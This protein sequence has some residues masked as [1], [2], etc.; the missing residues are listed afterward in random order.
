[1]DGSLGGIPSKYYGT[2][3]ATGVLP[4][5]S[6]AAAAAAA[7]ATAPPGGVVA[8]VPPGVAPPVGH[9]QTPFHP[10][11]SSAYASFFQHQMAVMSNHN[12]HPLNP[13]PHQQ[14]SGLAAPPGHHAIT[15]AIFGIPTTQIQVRG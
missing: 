15:S 13:H 7:A 8:S 4:P 9:P 2:Q 11:V 6:A 1:M 10:H 5:G 14:I 3:P 12:H